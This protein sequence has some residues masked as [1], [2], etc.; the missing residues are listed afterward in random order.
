MRV[1]FKFGFFPSNDKWQIESVNQATVCFPTFS[2]TKEG[3]AGRT[4]A[5]E[6]SLI[7]GLQNHIALSILSQDMASGGVC[8]HSEGSGCKRS[9]G[10]V[11]GNWVRV[12]MGWQECWGWLV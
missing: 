6:S 1:L 7:R 2:V 5:L 8:H 9:N 12:G 3:K 11:H 10:G 4:S